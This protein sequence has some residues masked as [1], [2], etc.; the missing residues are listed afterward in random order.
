MRK[1]FVILL[2]LCIALSFLAC[3]TEHDEEINQYHFY[4]LRSAILYGAEDGVISC[5]F[6]E[7]DHIPA[8]TLLKQYFLGPI[9]EHLVSPYP[10]G[11]TLE[12]VRVSNDSL[13]IFLSHEFSHLSDMEHTLA[14]ACL[15]KTCFSLFDV[16]VITI[17]VAGTDQ[18]MTLS[19]DSLTFIDSSNT[20]HT[21]IGTEPQTP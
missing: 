13:L 18:S 11:T 9:S 2:S 4:Y 10:I 12:S 3:G 1:L 8:E 16:S 15:A 17:R 19:A 6:H 20:I 5:E 21:V 7:R 14:C